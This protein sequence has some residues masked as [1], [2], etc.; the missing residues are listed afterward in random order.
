MH[1]SSSPELPY[2]PTEWAGRT[3]LIT[4]ATGFLG[5]RLAR[6]LLQHRAH[7]VAVVRECR[8]TSEFYQEGLAA[9]CTIVTGDLASPAFL[10]RTFEEHRFDAAFHLAANSDVEAP[11]HDPLPAFRIALEGTLVLLEQ[12]RIK[13]PSCATIVSSSDKAYGPQAVPYREQSN[14]APRHPYEVTK[15]CQDQIARSYAAAFGLPVTVTRCGNYFGPWDLAWRRIIPGTIRSALEG[16]PVTLRSDGRFSRDF[17]YIDDAVD[18]QLVL[19]ARSLGD[20]S[21][22][23]EAFNFSHEV[24]L[25]IVD[26]VRRLCA[27]LE[28]DAEP[29]VVNR[30]H[31]E[32]RSMRLDCRKA[33]EVLGWRPRFSFDHAL[34]ETVRW[35]RDYLRIK[36]RLHDKHPDSADCGAPTQG[37]R[38][39]N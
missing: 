32:I 15:A 2:D 30:A 37:S 16:G 14:L 19:A 28:Y 21:V 27:E 34:T 4:G 35:Y 38:A 10:E 23:G 36:P 1:P 7:V 26:I 39:I 13:Q 24:E 25:A 18:V 31:T 33:H 29:L 5:G 12:V 22:H 3:V 20:A 17:L 9:D 11:Q 6:R 8:P